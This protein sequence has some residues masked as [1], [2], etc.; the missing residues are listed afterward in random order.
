M[1]K[2]TGSGVGVAVSVS[3]PTPTL[4]KLERAEAKLKRG[5]VKTSA[6]LKTLGHAAAKATALLADPRNI[7]NIAKAFH[8]AKALATS[9]AVVLDRHG[10]QSAAN[11]IRA[12]LAKVEQTEAAI[13]S[14]APVLSQ[15]AEALN[16]IGQPEAA[17]ALNNVAAKL[18]E[19]S[20]F[21]PA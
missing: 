7:E 9:A 10:N 5:F 3:V 17:K 16:S 2:K 21:T 1:P 11:N 12:G 18:K 13:S 6:A 20:S 19:T 15:G 8:A 4:S 14:V